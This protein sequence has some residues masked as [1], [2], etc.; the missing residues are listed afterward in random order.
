[1]V[2]PVDPP[3]ADEDV[4]RRARSR[5]AY[6]AV[7][8]CPLPRCGDDTPAAR[9]DTYSATRSR[10]RRRAHRA[11]AR[12]RVARVGVSERGEA[13]VWYEWRAT[14]GTPR[15]QRLEAPRERLHVSRTAA[16]SDSRRGRE[17]VRRGVASAYAACRRD[18]AG[19]E[20]QPFG[21]AT[22]NARRS[23]ARSS[24]ENVRAT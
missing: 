7:N 17:A 24:S 4:R 22:P 10:S 21:L 8:V 5:A 12:E 23:S 20:P 3:V 16:S 13:S 18:E 15:R 6:V 14:A 2:R 9:A 19:M 11:R 1:V